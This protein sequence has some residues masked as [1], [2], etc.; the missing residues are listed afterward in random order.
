MR[1][2][3]IPVLQST[4]RDDFTVSV[5]QAGKTTT[6]VNWLLAATWYTDPRRFPWAWWWTAPTYDLALAGYL[7]FCEAADNAGIL[8]SNTERPPL[9]AR[10]THGVRVEGRSWHKPTNL[11]GH[12]VAGAV[13]DEFGELTRQAYANLSARRAE[14]VVH[15]LGFYRYLGNV[16]QIGG[17]G[18]ELW[19]KAEAGGRGMACRRWTWRERARDLVCTCGP[20]GAAIDPE[21][22]TSDRHRGECGRGL[23]VGFVENEAGRLSRQEFAQIYEAEWGDINELPVYDF[24]RERHVDPSAQILEGRPIDLACDFNV[25]PMVWVV[26]QHDTERAW[27]VDEIAIPG[28]ARTIQAC[29]EFKRRIPDRSRVVHVY[30]DA[31]GDHRDTR[32]KVT[33]YEQIRAELVGYYREVRFLVP[34]ANPPVPARINAYNARLLSASG[35]VRYGV[36]PRCI[37]LVRDLA[38]VSWR[39]GTREI[40]DRDKS[41]THASSAEGYRLARIWPT[42]RKVDRAASI[43]SAEEYRKARARWDRG[44]AGGSLLDADF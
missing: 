5:P 1:G 17:V 23:Y 27:A 13:V 43:G 21:L 14:T 32:S 33:D 24:I 29:Q 10:L 26:G 38:K 31:T 40:D 16:G 37:Y 2:Y 22:G 25:D 34:K 9:V 30:G 4:A 36:H 18:E 20:R 7:L 15:G 3:Q 28:G 35:L 12:P 42:E 6:G 19:N 8:R 41:L 11:R 44:K 39:T